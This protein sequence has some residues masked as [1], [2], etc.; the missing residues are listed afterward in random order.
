MLILPCLIV[1][2]PAYTMYDGQWCWAVG[3]AT[4]LPHQLSAAVGRDIGIGILLLFFKLL[5]WDDFS[6]FKKSS[7]TTTSSSSMS[8]AHH[9]AAFAHNV[10]PP[11]F[12]SLSDVEKALLLPCYLYWRGVKRCMS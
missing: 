3:V 8:V 7:S 10:I 5:G 11:S 1:G 6:D 12:P 2:N 9:K 4:S